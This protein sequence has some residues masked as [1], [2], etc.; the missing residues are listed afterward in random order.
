[1][2]AQLKLLSNLDISKKTRTSMSTL[3]TTSQTST[4]IIQQIGSRRQDLQ[5]IISTSRSCQD[6]TPLLPPISNLV[7]AWHSVHPL[8]L[9]FHNHS[10]S[11]PSFSRTPHHLFIKLDWDHLSPFGTPYLLALFI[12]FLICN[13]GNPFFHLSIN[14]FKLEVVFPI[15]AV[16]T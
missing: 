5:R 11:F 9:A 12:I 7:L 4:T 8:L 3:P 10:P 13:L 1:M 6:L 16:H 14:L 15:L 2:N